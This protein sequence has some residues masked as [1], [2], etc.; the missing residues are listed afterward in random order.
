MGPEI[1]K[2]ITSKLAIC[3]VCFREEVETVVH[4]DDPIAPVG[5]LNIRKARLQDKNRVCYQYE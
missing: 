2:R 3:T 5:Y 4:S 1:K